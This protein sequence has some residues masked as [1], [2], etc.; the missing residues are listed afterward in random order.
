MT[1]SKLKII[2]I[3]TLAFCSCTDNNRRESLRDAFRAFEA[4][5][6]PSNIFTVDKLNEFDLLRQKQE[7]IDERY[8]YPNTFVI[9]MYNNNTKTY[10]RV[11]VIDGFSPIENYNLLK[12]VSDYYTSDTTFL[13][14]IQLTDTINI[15]NKDVSSLKDTTYRISLNDMQSSYKMNDKKYI[16]LVF[17][18]TNPLK[19]ST[20][21][22]FAMWKREIV[23]LQSGNMKTETLNK[24]NEH[25]F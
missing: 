15:D 10:D 25:L 19:D 12:A 22:N 14:N 5:D 7:T 2:I 9:G 23:T 20:I 17:R 24:M 6:V 1:T 8:N 16:V 3:S 21:G 18:K 13:D 4:R 11:H